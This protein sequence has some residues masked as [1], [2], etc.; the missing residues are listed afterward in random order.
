MTFTDKIKKL[1]RQLKELRKEL[2]ADLAKY[3]SSDYLIKRKLK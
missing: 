1:D 2:E 3:T